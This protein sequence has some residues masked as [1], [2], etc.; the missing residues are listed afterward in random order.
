MKTKKKT[1]TSANTTRFRPG[2]TGQCESQLWLFTCPIGISADDNDPQQHWVAAESL[3]E[4][5]RYMRKRYDDFII[6]EAR[7]LCMIP[8]LSGAP[9]D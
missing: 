2:T 9:L 5:L 8:L 3:E 4:A 1:R 7:F 6:A